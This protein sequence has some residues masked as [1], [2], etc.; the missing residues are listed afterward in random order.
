VG[1]GDGAP[2]EDAALQVEGGALGRLERRDRLHQ[3][4]GDGHF[5]LGRHRRVQLQEHAEPVEAS[6]FH[7]QLLL[8]PA[9]RCSSAT[10]TSYSAARR[11]AAA[12]KICRCG[13]D[14]GF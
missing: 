2:A 10:A 13:P 3:A 7:V 9:S 1:A 8:E 14:A 11:P 12:E 6:V 4:T 5:H